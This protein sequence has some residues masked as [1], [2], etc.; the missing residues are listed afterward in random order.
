MLSDF[1]QE[2]S[3]CLAT[4]SYCKNGLCACKNFLS[5]S[6]DNMACIGKLLSKTD[7][8]FK[9]INV[10]TYQQAYWHVVRPGERV[11]GDTLARG[12]VSW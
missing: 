4:S 11:S 9:L 10:K 6:T 1:C 12:P 7:V 5:P 3:D 8:F 2:D